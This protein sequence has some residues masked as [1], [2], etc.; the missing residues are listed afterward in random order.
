METKLVKNPSRTEEHKSVEF[1]Y[2]YSVF[3]GFWGWTGAKI[4]T[5]RRAK[6]VWILGHIFGLICEDFGT[7]FGPFLRAKSLQNRVWQRPL[8]K[9]QFWRILVPTGGSLGSAGGRGPAS[10][11]AVVI[12]PF[13]RQNSDI[14]RVLSTLAHSGFWQPHNIVNKLT[15]IGSY[16]TGTCIVYIGRWIV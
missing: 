12:L 9:L 15:Y 3:G 16:L 13:G 8:K 14:P 7:H 4:D 10:S 6:R 5:I 1:G 11:G 2:P